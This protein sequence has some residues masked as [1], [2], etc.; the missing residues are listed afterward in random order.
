MQNKTISVFYDANRLPFKDAQRT[1][2]YPLVSGDVF[3]GANNVTTIRYYVDRIGGVENVTWLVVSKLPN[4][5]IANEVLNSNNAIYDEELGEHYLEFSI[6]SYYT[7]LKG[8]VYLSLNGYQG[9]VEVEQDEDTGIYSIYGTPTIQATGCIKIGINYAPQTIQGTHFTTSDLQQMLGLISDKA[10]ISDVIL[11]VDDISSVD[12]TGYD[13]GQLF[14]NKATKSYY[15][16]NGIYKTRYDISLSYSDDLSMET[17]LQS[18]YQ[19]HSSKWFTLKYSNNLVLAYITET[20]TPTYSVYAYVLDKANQTIKY[21]EKINR[22]PA[23]TLYSILEGTPTKEF[24]TKSYVDSEI[25]TLETYVNNN[26]VGLTNTQTISGQKTFSGKTIF[27]DPNLYNSYITTNSKNYFVRVGVTTDQYVNYRLPFSYSQLSGLGSV[28]NLELVT[29]NTVQLNATSGS[30]S[31]SYASLLSK[32]NSK[33]LYINQDLSTDIYFY[34]GSSTGSQGESSIFSTIPTISSGSNGT[35]LFRRKSG[36]V[37]TWNN[38]YIVGFEATFQTYTKDKIDSLLAD[39]M[40]REF[41]V[42]DIATYP[43]LD[44]FLESEGEEGVIYLYPI[45]TSDLDQGYYQYVYE[46]SAWLFLGTTNI[47]LSGYVETSRTIAGI[48]LENDISASALTDALV[49][50]TNSD[51]DALF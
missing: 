31:N 8:D 33:M 38:N 49:F 15:I 1:I 39:I 25:N 20:I 27:S 45:D 40:Q 35:I 6:S 22:V 36:N 14:Y 43:T 29:D 34:V 24:A 44:D 7:T 48:S 13:E 4:S 11:V 47:D 32:H 51:V 26:F 30:L 50:A 16:K 5:Q 10:N 23:I 42:V 46:D 9:G 12:I 3:N 41:Q 37:F 28:L 21:Y 19:Q 2:H 17:T 18:L